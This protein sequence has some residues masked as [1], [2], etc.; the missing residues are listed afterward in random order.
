MNALKKHPLYWGMTI[1]FC[2]TFLYSAWSNLV[3]VEE[4]RQTMTK[5]GFPLHLLPFLGVAKGLGIL[6]LIWPGRPLLKEWAYAGFTFDLLGAAYAHVAVGDPGEA[7]SALTVLAIGA[8]SYF[9]RPADRRVRGLA[10]GDRDSLGSPSN[11][12]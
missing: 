9:Q 12:D 4:Q 5:L 1:L 8:V 11:D 2:L 10:D 3:M 7:M 6:V